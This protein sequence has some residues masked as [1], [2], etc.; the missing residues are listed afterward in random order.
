M[1]DKQELFIEDAFADILCREPRR[2]KV[3]GK[4]LLLY[5]ESLGTHLYLKRVIRNLGFNH[6]RLSENPMR[7]VLRVVTDNRDAVCRYIAYHTLGNGNLRDVKLLEKNAATLAEGD[8]P[9]LAATLLYVA[10]C[11]D[12][13]AY[14]RHYH[15]D[16]DIKDRA[17]ISKVKGEGSYSVTIGG[18][19][20]LGSVILPACEKLNATITEV[21]EEIPYVVTVLALY[22]GITDIYLT[23][24]EARKAGISKSRAVYDADSLDLATIQQIMSRK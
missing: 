15:I 16:I 14:I 11:N 3:G 8:D 17:R 12:V 1:K 6:R 22:D 18:R 13:E 20:V 10:Q 9:D 7:E 24:D 4:A 23:K 5:P 19:T 21:L 2:I